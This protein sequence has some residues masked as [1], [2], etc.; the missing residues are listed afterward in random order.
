MRINP[1]RTR[2]EKDRDCGG[3][4]KYLCAS[5]VT[6]EFWFVYIRTYVLCNYRIDYS[7]VQ[8]LS[9]KIYIPISV[10]FWIKSYRNW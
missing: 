9:K 2:C 1:E 10:V 7:I 3:H 6:V 5:Q 4:S 8:G